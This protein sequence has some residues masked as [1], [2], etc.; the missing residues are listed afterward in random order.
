MKENKYIHCISKYVNKFKGLDS[1]QQIIYI[2][3]DLSVNKFSTNTNF[4]TIKQMCEDISRITNQLAKRK[5]KVEGK[6]IHDNR[7]KAEKMGKSSHSDSIYSGKTHRGLV[8]I[9]YNIYT[10]RQLDTP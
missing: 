3:C 7:I 8:K 5:R 2:F 6:Y 1:V 4:C 10:Y 9:S